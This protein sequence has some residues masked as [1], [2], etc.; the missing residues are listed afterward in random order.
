VTWREELRRVQLSNGRRLIGASFRGVPFL[1]EESER[2]GGRR[3]VKHEFPLR[4]DPFVEDLGRRARTFPITG[5]VIGDN[6]LADRDALL[7]ALEDAA[8]PGELVHPYHGVRRA[9][10]ETLSVKE[11]RGNGGIA[12]FTIEFAETPAQAPVPSVVVDSTGQVGLSA[13]AA[14]AAAKT[15]LAQKYSVA[16]LASHALAS[17]EKAIT[18]AAAAIKDKLGPVITTAQEA[19]ELTGQVALITAE[20]S[21]LARTPSSIV[22][23]FVDAITGLVDTILAAPGG[24]M[25]GLIDAYS[26][27]LGQPVIP[28]TSTRERELANQIALTS[29]LRRV[30]AIE[31]AKLSP[32]VPY[33]SIDA[34]LAARD[35]L[36]SILDEQAALAGDDT[37]PALMD[38]RSQMLA[39]VPGSKAFAAILDVTRRVPVPSLLLAYQLYGDVDLEADLVARNGIP[40]PG[41][42]A[43]DLKVLSNG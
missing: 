16:G 23:Q 18:S 9:I 5:Y 26:V 28:T 13:A 34:A 25:N 4:D 39:A 19:A 12:T 41:F 33:E 29:A 11:S 17:A 20:A 38:L 36:T 37:Y 21:S 42:V 14:L 2:T 1:V 24:V 22:D 35:Q 31:A 40:H 3:T 27:D 32:V 10:C 7:A 15:D 43:G 8:G 6:Y 30:F